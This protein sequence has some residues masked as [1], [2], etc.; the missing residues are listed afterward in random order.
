MCVGEA[1][2]KKGRVATVKI[3]SGKMCFSGTIKSVETIGRDAQTLA[4]RSRT[5]YMLRALQLD[6]SADFIA[7]PFIS[8]MWSIGTPSWASEKSRSTP[9]L[10]IPSDRTLNRAQEEAVNACLSQDDCDRIVVIHGPPGT[11]KTTVIAATVTSIIA[12]SKEATVYLVAQSNVAVKNIAEKLVSVHFFDFKI[13]VSH[14][15]HYDWYDHCP[16]LYNTRY[17]ETNA[18]F[19]KARPL[20]QGQTT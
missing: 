18:S 11:G 17:C 3:T 5:R 6:S 7:H 19:V 4:E 2:R 10:Y 20:V 1:L 12:S 16:N 8:R 9:T 13:L 14:N 15:F